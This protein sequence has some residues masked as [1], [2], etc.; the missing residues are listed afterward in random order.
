MDTY[1]IGNM[2]FDCVACPRA[3]DGDAAVVTAVD[4]AGPNNIATVYVFPDPDDAR[5]ASRHFI[6]V[7]SGASGVVA[8]R[9]DAT[10]LAALLG[11]CRRKIEGAKKGSFNVSFCPNWRDLFAPAAT[12]GAPAD[13]LVGEEV[14]VSNLVQYDSSGS[15]AAEPLFSGRAT[16]VRLHD[17][18]PD[19]YVLSV[20]SGAGVAHTDRFV[21]LPKVSLV[22]LVAASKT[23]DVELPARLGSLHA[24][25]LAKSLPASTAATGLDAREFIELATHAGLD[26]TGVTYDMPSVGAVFCGLVAELQALLSSRVGAAS[27]TW[28]DLNAQR[29]GSAIKRFAAEPAV[30]APAG[31]AGG[32]GVTAAPPPPQFPLYESLSAALAAQLPE[33]VSAATC[34]AE[35]RSY[36]AD[37]CAVAATKRL[38]VDHDYVAMGAMEG[39]LKDG[40]QSAESIAAADLSSVDKVRW[41]CVM[42]QAAGA[43]KPTPASKPQAP[44][45]QSINVLA[46]PASGGEEETR[47]RSVLRG[48][49]AAVMGD[50]SALGRLLKFQK[51]ADAGDSDALRLA[52]DT[53][54]MAPLHRL[55]TSGEGID[56]A[57]AGASRLDTGGVGYRGLSR[58]YC[59]PPRTVVGLW[60]TSFDGSVHLVDPWA[61]TSRPWVGSRMRYLLV[62]CCLT[63]CACQHASY[64]RSCTG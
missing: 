11:R 5:M 42:V 9:L 6:S 19:T 58:V 53:E 1:V 44:S 35:V 59:P 21:W 16:V 26:V 12:G 54:S 29:L 10:N 47:L 55:C 3:N 61:C 50:N 17:V 13:A 8:D 28:P 27:R 32:G 7:N 33:G 25:K 23:A 24:F 40:L 45:M 14:T 15:P 60:L 37:V 62:K 64:T 22:A 36:V 34:L 43:A 49:A 18:V 57:L 51:L 2:C 31:N 4:H 30:P 52:V 56:R 38:I 41:F 63:T 20:G 39:F 46:A 48:D